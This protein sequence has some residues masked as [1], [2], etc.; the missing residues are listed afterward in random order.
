MQDNEDGTCR[1]A[2]HGMLM[3]DE[4]TLRVSFDRPGHF[5]PGKEIRGELRKTL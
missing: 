1:Q 3:P 5:G 4:K 2:V